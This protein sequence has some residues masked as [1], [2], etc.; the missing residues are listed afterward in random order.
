MKKY[1]HSHS[2]E[3]D[4]VENEDGSICGQIPITWLKVSPPRKILLSEEQ[5]RARA[6]RLQKAREKRLSI[7]SIKD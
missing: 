5:K 6:E 1:R 7:N 3:V 2:D 4:F